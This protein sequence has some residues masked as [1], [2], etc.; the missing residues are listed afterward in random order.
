MSLDPSGKTLLAA[1]YGGGSVIAYAVEADGSLGARTGFVQHEGSGGDPSRQSAPHAHSILASPDGRFALAVDLGIDK[2][3]VY[4]LGADGSLIPNEPAFGAVASAAGPRH[5]TFSPDGRFV[6]VVNELNSTVTQF[7]YDAAGGVLEALEAVS[8]LAPD[9]EGTSYCADIHV[10]P[11]GRFV[12]ASN[13]G[14]DS[15]AVFRVDAATGGLTWLDAV[16]TGGNWPRNFALSPDGRF[17]LAANQRSASIVAFRLD[18]ET[19][20]PVE[21]GSRLE[22]DQPACVKFSIL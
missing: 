4:R 13:R 19:G 14:H 21:T 16:S 1:N 18:E 12:Y 15:I 22:V 9:H 17:L 8:T 2:V 6:Y 11:T 5:L 10:H 20:M 3:M 7:R